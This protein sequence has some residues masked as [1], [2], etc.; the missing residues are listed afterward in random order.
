LVH[1][2]A[3]RRGLGL[4]PIDRAALEAALAEVAPK[5]CPMPPRSGR[6]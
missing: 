6:C 2:D 4:D 5:S 3:L 1:H